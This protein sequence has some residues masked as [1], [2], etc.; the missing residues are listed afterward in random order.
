MRTVSNSDCNILAMLRKFSPLAFACTL[1]LCLNGASVKNVRAADTPP[2][3]VDSNRL[4]FINLT[5]KD[6]LPD[7]NIWSISQDRQ[8]F[9]WFGTGLGGLSRF[10]GY[11]FRVFQHNA[12]DPKSISHNWI[13]AV[14]TDKTGTLWVGTN[15]G[16]SSRRG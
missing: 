1:L 14:F 8:G 5:V 2:L 3:F 16:G 4:E 11:E 12:A 7:N 6:G 15:G 13:W 10:D 9:M